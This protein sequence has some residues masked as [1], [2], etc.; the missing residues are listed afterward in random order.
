M[1]STAS[2]MTTAMITTTTRISTSVKPLLRT[3]RHRHGGASLPLIERRRADVGVVAFAARLAVAPVADDVVVAAV[4]AGTRVLID[5]VPGVLGH[6]RQIASRAVIGDGGIVRLRNERLQALFGRRVFEIIEPVQVQRGL[7]GPDV[8]RGAGDASLV[9][10][11][12]NLRH[13][14]RPEYCENDHHDHDLDQRKTALALVH[15]W[16]HLLNDTKTED[17]DAR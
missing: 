7:N 12:Q 1:D 2:A 14:E 6:R 17:H 8:A 9:D 5:V 10:V 13:H 11:L 15:S 16:T 4:G 3:V